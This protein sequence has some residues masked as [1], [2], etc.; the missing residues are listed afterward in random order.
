MRHT[1]LISALFLAAC[2][3]QAAPAPE[4][5]PPAPVSAAE[6]PTIPFPEGVS[7]NP[8]DAPAGAYNVDTA[9]TRVF[10][11]VRHAGLALFTGRFD[12]TTGTLTFDPQ[13]PENSSVSVT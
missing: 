4:V 6:A 2:A 11:T 7:T 10:W 5:G 13:H 12:T 3:T 8:A 1:A 9:H